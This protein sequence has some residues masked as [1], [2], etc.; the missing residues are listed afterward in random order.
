M[1]HNYVKIDHAVFTAV[2]LQHGQIRPVHK[3]N[4]ESS[5]AEKLKMA[6]SFKW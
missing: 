1:D 5:E 2:Y 4:K 3:Y 6:L